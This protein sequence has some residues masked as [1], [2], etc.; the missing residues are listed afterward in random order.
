MGARNGNDNPAYGYDAVAGYVYDESGSYNC[1]DCHIGFDRETNL[2]YNYF[3]DYDPGTGRYVQSDPIGLRGGINTYG[4]ANQNPLSYVDPDGK[5][6]IGAI[7]GGV[8]AYIGV[9]SS[10]P[11]APASTYVLSVLA[12]AGIGA[13]TQ[14]ILP[15]GLVAGLVGGGVAGAT[16]NTLGQY[17]GATTTNQQFTW[18]WCQTAT[19]G[20]IGAVTGGLG[21]G[22]GAIGSK[23]ITNAGGSAAQSAAFG[24]AASAGVGGT[25]AMYLNLPIPSSYGGFKPG[26]ST[27]QSCTCS[28]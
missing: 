15:S 20:G 26:G 7:I 4:Y 24:N 18:N 19:Q 6:I 3:R 2:N 13:L 8:S 22:V 16:G 9:A 10:T 21:A 11:N 12:G 25:A 27:P 1:D 5:F 23:M 28:F 14:G 17:I